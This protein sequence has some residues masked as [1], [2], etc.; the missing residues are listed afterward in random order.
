MRRA[1]RAWQR[2]LSATQLELPM[3][4]QN[5]NVDSTVLR[6]DAWPR[7]AIK[8]GPWSD[9]GGDV[10]L[11]GSASGVCAQPSSRLRSSA[12]NVQCGSLQLAVCL[13]WV[14]C[15]CFG[16]VQNGRVHVTSEEWLSQ[17]WS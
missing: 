16:G 4:L 6:Y 3:A 8:W 2:S 11:M 1:A 10:R 15:P 7:L 17:G 14:S 5:V 9:T 13:G 12:F